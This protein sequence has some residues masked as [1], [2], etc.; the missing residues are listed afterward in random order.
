M[1]GNAIDAKTLEGFEEVAGA[2]DVDGAEENT[3][4]SQAAAMPT[5]PSQEAAA[6]G[7][8]AA[9][10]TASL[11]SYRALTES[12]A[13]TIGELTERVVSLQTQLA[14][15]VSG[16]AS[17]SDGSTPALDAGP[18]LGEDYVP[19]AELDITVN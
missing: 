12:Q 7:T 19:L 11:D 17:Y 16:G 14:Q 8:P 6:A 13:A 10:D 4:N 3:I 15:L 1:P 9:E 2:S 5:G 18:E